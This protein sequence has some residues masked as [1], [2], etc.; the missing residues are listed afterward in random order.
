MVNPRMKRNADE[1]LFEKVMEHI[2]AAVAITN[3]ILAKADTERKGRTMGDGLFF[4]S[5]KDAY[6]GVVENKKL[7]DDEAID[8]LV[9]AYSIFLGERLPNLE[10]KVKSLLLNIIKAK[11]ANGRDLMEQKSIVEK[12]LIAKKKNNSVYE[13]L[14]NLITEPETK[15]AQR[16]NN[17]RKDNGKGKKP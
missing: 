2:D 10:E 12:Q 8:I 1:A 4:T 6:N 3:T 9:F 17:T 15:K 13:T 7:C 14:Y 5:C 16:A 11:L